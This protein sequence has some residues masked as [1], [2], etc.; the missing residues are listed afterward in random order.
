MVGRS[1]TNRLG[2]TLIELMI[3]VAII[4]ILAAIAI[5][6]FMLLQAKSKQ[7]EARILMSG[8]FN[9]EIA[10]YAENSEFT[11]DFSVLNFQPASDPKYYKN[12][13]LNINGEPDHFTATCSANIDR[14][15]DWDVWIITE[16][17]RE[18]WNQFNDLR[19]TINPYP[20]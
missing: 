17:N 2:F 4:A 7:S 16:R 8:V 9:A 5:P 1:H 14:D 20:Y 13:Y 10:Y 12:W 6:S 19:N 15:T 11:G 18:P 3:T